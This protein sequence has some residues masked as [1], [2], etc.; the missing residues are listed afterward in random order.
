VLALRLHPDRRLELHEEAIPIPGPGDALI[1]VSA[2]GLCG[3]DRHWALE[4]GIGDS[5]LDVPL[6]LGH[7]FAGIAESGRWA[8]RLVAVDPAIPCDHC[9]VCRRGA[10]NLCP[11][12]RFAGHGRTDGALR[13][14]I[15]W[16]E[17]CC[18]PLTDRLSAIEGALV[19][20]LAVG[21]LATDLAGP[22]ADRR[23]GVVGCG[24][25]GL[26]LVALARLAGARTIVAIDPLAHR[27][28][29]AAELGATATIRPAPGWDPDDRSAETSEGRDLEVVFDA[30]DDDTV[31]LA[32]GLAAPGAEVVLAGIPSVD[33]ISF[34]AS[35]ARR[36]GL[37]LR[38]VRRSTPATFERAVDLAERGVIDLAGLVTLR[39]ALPDAARAFDALIDRSGIKV[40]VEPAPA[41]TKLEELVA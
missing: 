23:V 9:G 20:P 6:V 31:D 21:I 24:P 22:L 4:G 34:R 7:E 19:E 12:L 38:L 11:D 33:R 37:S 39:V 8:G 32:V 36:K 16:P 1:R 25:I 10:S 18:H 15:A 26:L 14:W 5:V 3:S 28:S 30:T 27:L 41:Q 35:I 17:R 29:A 13:E 40:M 2:V